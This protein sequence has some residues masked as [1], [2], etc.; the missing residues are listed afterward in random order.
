MI[1]ITANAAKE[2]DRIRISRQKPNSQFRLRVKKGG[3]SG[4]LYEFNLDERILANDRTF[5]SN[6]ISVAIDEFSFPYLDEL[7]LDYS[8]DLMGGGFRFQNPNVTNNCGCGQSFQVRQS[9]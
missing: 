2:I 9:N 7:K 6:G 8:E 4:F 1:Y 5:E 3:C